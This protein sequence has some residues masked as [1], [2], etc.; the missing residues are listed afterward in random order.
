[1]ENKDLGAPAEAVG[2]S[3]SVEPASGLDG[4]ATSIPSA[5]DWHYCGA[6]RGGCSC[7]TTMFRDYPICKVTS[8]DWGDDYPSIRL[9]GETS[10]DLKA[11]AYM[12]QIT[13]GSIREDQAKVHANLIAA[14]PD[15]YWA[16]RGWLEAWGNEAAEITAIRKMEEAVGRVAQGGEARRAETGTGSVEDESAVAESD[17]PE[18]GRP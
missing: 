5:G 8:G 6:N 1:M 3:P 12:E 4:S 18:G 14:A 10:F 15:L 9:V 11:E 7:M 16:C 13:Y 2:L 17:A